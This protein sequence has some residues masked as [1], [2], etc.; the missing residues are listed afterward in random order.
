[1]LI[2]ILLAFIIAKI[3]RYHLK[4]LFRAYALFPFFLVEIVYWI[5]QITIFTGHYSVIQYA[6]YLKSAYF[7][8][9][10]IPILV[11]KLFAPALIGS[12]S[13]LIG[14]GLN[15]LVIISNGGKMPVY[16][17]LSLFTGYFSKAPLSAIDTLHCMG[18]DTTKLKFLC[19]YIDIGWSILSIGDLFIHAFAVIIMY[20]SIKAINR[21]ALEKA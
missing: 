3:K 11:Y 16:P 14:T 10:L 5:L 4:P 18:T 17:T 8:A 19:D 21:V 9:L 1:M 15:K 6:D 20:Y 7:L 12:A 13:V 2:S